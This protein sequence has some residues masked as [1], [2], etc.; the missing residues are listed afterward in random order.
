MNIAVILLS[1]KGTR[2]GADTPKQFLLVNNRPLY[3]YSLRTFYLN[4]KIDKI[5]LVTNEEHINDVKLDLKKYGYKNKPI[6]VVAG[7]KERYLSVRNA[8]NALSGDEYQIDDKVLIHDGVR[9]NVSERIIK[10]N[11][12]GLNIEPCALTAIK[13]PDDYNP[14]ERVDTIHLLHNHRY[15][16][17]TPQ[18]F[19]LGILRDIYKR[20]E[21]YNPYPFTDDISL[22]IA[23][24]YPYIIIDGD[25]DNYKITT[26]EDLDRFTKSQK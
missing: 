22:A 24:N 14:T 8:L 11:I 15:R 21:E 3:L 7:G 13:A 5:L 25:E 20:G 10:E 23:C 18:S 19:R 16:A 26:Q 4:K 12:T 9:P 17:Q 2:M 1:G 6:E